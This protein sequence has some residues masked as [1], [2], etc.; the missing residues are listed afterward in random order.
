MLSDEGTMTL[1]ISASAE[2]TLVFLS[3]GRTKEIMVPALASPGWERVHR[4]RRQ[5]GSFPH[6]AAPSTSLPGIQVCI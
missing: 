2:I 6:A 4:S 5:T 1:P 3:Y